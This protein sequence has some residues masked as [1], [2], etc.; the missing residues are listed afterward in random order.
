MNPP[1]LFVVGTLPAPFCGDDG[2]EIKE[3]PDHFTTI[4]LSEIVRDT[5]HDAIDYLE[6]DIKASPM[7]K[8]LVTRLSLILEADKP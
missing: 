6:P 3:N 5:L 2:C 7:A 1:E 4:R 8:S